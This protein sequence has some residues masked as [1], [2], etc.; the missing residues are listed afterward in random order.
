MEGFSL[1]EDQMNE[2]IPEDN[3][4]AEMELF[5]AKVKKISSWNIKQDRILILSTH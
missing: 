2:I 3:V 1:S 5:T 4:L